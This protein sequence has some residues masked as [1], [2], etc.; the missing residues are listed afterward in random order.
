MKISVHCCSVSLGLVTLWP[1]VFGDIKISWS[2]PPCMQDSTVKHHRGLAAQ[3]LHVQILSN[4]CSLPC[5]LEHMPQKIA[6]LLHSCRLPLLLTLAGEGTGCTAD[7]YLKGLVTK[8]VDVSEAIRLHKLQAVSL[9]PPL[10]EKLYL[11]ANT[12]Q[13]SGRCH[14]ASSLFLRM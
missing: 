5:K 10:Q 7:T 1:F 8:E 3:R 2:L 12:S 13:S 9:V 11:K 6:V 4:Q 14:S